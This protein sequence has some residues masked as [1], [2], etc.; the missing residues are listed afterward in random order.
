ME[1]RKQ[2]SQGANPVTMWHYRDRDGAEVDLLLE[3]ADGRVVGI[4]V[5]AASTV[6]GRD[7]K[8]LR[9]LAER[10]GERFHAG[11]VLSTMPEPIA[12]GQRITA[13]P[14]STMWE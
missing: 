10:L 7:T 11:F 4:E 1:I 13:L 6:S 8:G 9:L 5:K 2:L 3:H 14:I 12:L